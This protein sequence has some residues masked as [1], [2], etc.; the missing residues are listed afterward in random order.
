MILTDNETKID[1]LNNEAIASMCHVVLRLHDGGLK[2]YEENEH[3]LSAE[4]VQW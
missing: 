2:S 3:I 4:E 1:L